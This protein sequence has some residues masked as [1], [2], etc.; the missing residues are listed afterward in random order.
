MIQVD[1]CILMLF[2]IVSQLG[3]SFKCLFGEDVASRGLGFGPGS[4]QKGER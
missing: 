3:I 2:L 4:V 1:I